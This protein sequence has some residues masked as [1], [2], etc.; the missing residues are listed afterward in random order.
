MDGSRRLFIT[1]LKPRQREGRAVA[2]AALDE[3][4]YRLTGQRSEGLGRELPRE[5]EEQHAP[6]RPTEDD[7]TQYALEPPGRGAER[8]RRQGG[9]AMPTAAL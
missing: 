2:A 7:Q 4:P 3:F 6:H 8:M 5:D 1:T 9:R